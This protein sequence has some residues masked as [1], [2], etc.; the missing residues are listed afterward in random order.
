MGYSPWD[1][2]ESDMTEGWR[3]HSCHFPR[4]LTLPGLGASQHLAPVIRV[5]AQRPT[6]GPCL[7]QKGP[8]A[9]DPPP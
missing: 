5:T 1:H 4:E 7:P 8:G 9:S 6:R 2:T 3:T